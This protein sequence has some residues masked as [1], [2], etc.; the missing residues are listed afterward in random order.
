[1]GPYAAMPMRPA[2]QGDQT[3][4]HT[5]EHLFEVFLQ[6]RQIFGVADD[7]EEILVAHEVEPR[8]RGPLPL[9]VLSEG[10]LHLGQE[11][12]EALQ[13]PLDALDVEHVHHHPRLG[14]L[15]VAKYGL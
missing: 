2:V 12:G 11:V 9:Q 3:H 7:L 4:V 14:H 15:E 13:R 1:M 8:E 10:L 5:C 6:P